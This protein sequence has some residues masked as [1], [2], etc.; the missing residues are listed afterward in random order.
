VKKR[1]L[2]GSLAV[3]KET[4]CVLKYHQD[5]FNY[6]QLKPNNIDKIQLDMIPEGSN[7]LEIGCATGYMGEYL[8]QEKQ[9]CFL[10]IEAEEAPSVAAGKRG[11]NVLFGL[12]EEETIKAKINAHIAE[13]GPFQIIFMSQVIEHIAN[14]DHTLEVLKQWMHPTCSLVVSTCSIAH[15]RCRFRLLRGI[16]KYENYGTF[17]HS[18]LRFF[19][20]NSFRELLEQC[21][22]T[23]VDFGY[24][25]EDICPFKIFFGTRIIA[26]SDILR[27][28]PFFGMRLRKRYTD[29][30]KNLIGHQFVFKVQLVE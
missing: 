21:G 16:W 22:F 15:W 6:R 7:V 8:V 29:L 23:V 11:L 20:I 9:C 28:I 10:G 18:H 3:D 17:D 25:F 5:T 2:S 4:D 14:P 13:H 1:K 30:A 24:E 12:I 19:T 26:P 27:L